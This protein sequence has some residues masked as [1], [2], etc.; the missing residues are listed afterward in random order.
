MNLIK[1]GLKISYYRKLAGM[2]QEELA[3]ACAL[4]AG[5]I[6]QLEAPNCYFCPS[7]KT[8]FLIGEALH[9]SAAKLLDIED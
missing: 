7:L 9:V 2:T 1:I 6:S 4:S 3:E 8:L 5:Y